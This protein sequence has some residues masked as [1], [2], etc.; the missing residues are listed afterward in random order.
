MGS[1]QIAAGPRTLSS[2]EV[3]ELDP[4]P[5]TLGDPKSPATGLTGVPGRLLGWPVRHLRSRKP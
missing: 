2:A 5:A 4:Y 1:A 3:G